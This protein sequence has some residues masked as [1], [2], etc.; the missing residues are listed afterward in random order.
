M[1]EESQARYAVLF[2]NYGT[3]SVQPTIAS[4]QAKQ[5]ILQFVE[6]RGP[7]LS[8]DGA[9]MLLSAYDN[10]IARPFTLGHRLASPDL[11]RY[12]AMTNVQDF[13]EDVT[14][15]SNRS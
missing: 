10:M 9:L 2:A 4:G 3:A 7:F 1:D 14:E 11:G 15:P 13:P 6:N 5:F 12:I 8:A